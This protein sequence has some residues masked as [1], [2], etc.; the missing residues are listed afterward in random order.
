MSETEKQVGCGTT[1]ISNMTLPFRAL[2]REALFATKQ[3]YLR[4]DCSPALPKDTGMV[5]NK[6]SAAHVSSN[7]TLPAYVPVRVKSFN[8]ETVQPPPT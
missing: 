1:A 2:V 6:R 4:G 8:F 5:C 7:K 3:S